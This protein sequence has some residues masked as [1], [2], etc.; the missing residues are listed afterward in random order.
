MIPLLVV[1]AIS[2]PDLLARF[3]AGIDYPVERLLV[4]D[5]SPAQEM[6][7]TNING[8]IRQTLVFGAPWNLGVA[9]SWNI[10]L[11]A[12]DTWCV[13]ANVDTDLAPG[14]L[15]I[16]AGIMA[17]ASPRWI[18]MDGD[19][20]AFGI[21]V[22]T[23]AEVGLFDENFHP[24][25]CEDADYEYRCRLA[26]VPFGFAWTGSRHVDSTTIRSD[27]RYA[28]ENKRTYIENVAYYRAKWG[29]HLRG[30]EMYRSPFGRGGS[31]RDWTLD[32]PRLRSQHWDIERDD[33]HELRRVGAA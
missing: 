16:L 27:G 22:A 4:I 18:G 32:M 11:K 33:E 24:I 29:G 20:R 7:P 9:A 5:N 28:K 10:A 12:M 15:A 31:I 30:G 17:P 2:R 21:N 19:W 13:V 14:A 25:Y 26:G 1:P 3:I 23:V 8:H 6:E